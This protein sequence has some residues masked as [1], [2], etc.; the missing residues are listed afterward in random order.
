MYNAYVGSESVTTVHMV[1]GVRTYIVRTYVQYIQLAV[2]LYS[3]Q[4]GTVCMYCTLGSVS[5]QHTQCVCILCIVNTAS[6]PTV[7]YTYIVGGEYVCTVCRA[8]NILY[9]VQ[10]THTRILHTYVDLTYLL[11]YMRF[12]FIKLCT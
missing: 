2:Y 11:F 12:N 6:R 5:V 8:S 3:T 1:G 4:S 7:Q 10:Y 9:N